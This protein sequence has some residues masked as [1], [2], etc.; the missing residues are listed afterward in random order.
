[1]GKNRVLQD[2]QAG[3]YGSGGEL[4]DWSYYDTATLAVATTV[5][6]LFTIGLG[7]GAVPKTLQTTNMTT[8][9]SIPQGQNFTVHAIKV[10][11]NTNNA[12]ATAD[13]LAFY[14]M[15][16]NTTVEVILPGK[17]SLGTWVLQELFGMSVA[18]AVVPT[19]A[20]DNL[21]FNTPRYHGV[22]PLNIPLVL[23]ALTPFELRMTHH[24]AVTAGLA[25]DR[26]QISL[27]GKLRRSS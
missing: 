21:D 6:R 22:F 3:T 4:I 27:S 9:G 12:L 20:G 23:A 19:V 14:N 17:D 8:G 10:F 5:H 25:D 26:I 24:V 18:A 13:V 7:G 1:M 16:K 15:L 11:Y 2:L